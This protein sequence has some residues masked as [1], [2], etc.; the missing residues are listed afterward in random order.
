MLKGVFNF[1]LF[2]LESGHRR[3]RE[4]GRITAPSRASRAARAS[5]AE[6]VALYDE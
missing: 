3:L 5:W 4:E 2:K 6:A 1:P